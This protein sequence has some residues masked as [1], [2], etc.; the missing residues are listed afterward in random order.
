MLKKIINILT[1]WGRALNIIP[2][3]PNARVESA[4]R[5][6]ICSVCPAAETKKILQTLNGSVEPVHSL[7]CTKCGCPCLE[8]TLVEDEQCPLNK[9]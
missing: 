3:P 2:T 1:G 6:M 9:W 4:R 5:L 8:K 7:I